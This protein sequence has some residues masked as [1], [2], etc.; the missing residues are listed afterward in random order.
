MKHTYEM[1]SSHDT[2]PYSIMMALI[3]DQSA[4][5]Y[6][7]D[8]VSFLSLIQSMTSIPIPPLISH[9]QSHYGLSQ[10]IIA[11]IVALHIL[12]TYC[13]SYEIQSRMCVI[14]GTM[15]L[16]KQR[17]STIGAATTYVAQTLIF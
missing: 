3:H 16:Q 2:T 7:H 12:S 10:E 8:T 13:Q 11:T 15:Y 17:L 9:L 5:G 6:F 4:S 1:S 14:K